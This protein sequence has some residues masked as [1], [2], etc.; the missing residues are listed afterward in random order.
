MLTSYIL[1]S[2]TVDPCDLIQT[3]GEKLPK[4]LFLPELLP[5]T[6]NSIGI[7]LGIKTKASCRDVL[8]ILGDVKDGFPTPEKDFFSKPYFV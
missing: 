3:I 4:P 7:D 5:K 6:N 1:S 2:E 8:L